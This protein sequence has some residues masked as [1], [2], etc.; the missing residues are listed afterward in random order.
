MQGRESH[1]GTPGG[2]C[3]GHGWPLL[4]LWGS[5]LLASGAD[6]EVASGFRVHHAWVSDFWLQ[7]WESRGPCGFK[8]PG[9]W[10]FIMAPPGNAYRRRGSDQEGH[11]L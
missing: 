5:E 10:L 8:P 3:E 6:G 11:E 9:L 1:L 4:A 7:R 2:P